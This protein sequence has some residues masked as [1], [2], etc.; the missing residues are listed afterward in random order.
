MDFKLG[1]QIQHRNNIGYILGF[2]KNYNS[3]V[4]QFGSD[5]GGH[6]GTMSEYWYEEDR[7]TKIPYYKGKNRFYVFLDS[8]EK[9]NNQSNYEIY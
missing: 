3:V 6:D 1:D 9:I 4:I 2:N 8:I 7:K 5:S